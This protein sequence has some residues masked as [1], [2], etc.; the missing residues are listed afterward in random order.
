M[1]LNEI[2]PDLALQIFKNRFKDFS[3]FTFVFVGA[4][5]LGEMKNLAKVYLASLPSVGRIEKGRY[6]GD[7]PL[8]GNET[9]KSVLDW[10]RKRASE[11]CLRARRNGRRRIGIYSVSL[12][13]C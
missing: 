9:S 13:I 4:I 7:D 8:P 2:D 6:L 10:R 5:D 1:L 11:S 12:G 3:D